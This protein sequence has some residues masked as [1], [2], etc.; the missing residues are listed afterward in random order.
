MRIRLSIWTS[1][2][3]SVAYEILKV[4]RGGVGVLKID[5]DKGGNGD[6]KQSMVTSQ[7]FIVR[8][9]GLHGISYNCVKKAKCMPC[10]HEYIYN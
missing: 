6:K 10:S 1:R 3:T 2:S 5:T 4:G 7:Y 8:K 9:V